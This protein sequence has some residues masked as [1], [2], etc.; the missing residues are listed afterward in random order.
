MQ[1]T[2]EPIHPTAH[3]APWSLPP[4]AQPTQSPSSC[5]PSPAG[6]CL[7]GGSARR[8]PGRES[9]AWSQPSL[10]RRPGHGATEG[11]A[12][13]VPANTERL[14]HRRGCL[15]PGG[16]KQ[17]PGPDLFPSSPPC[18][19][20]CLQFPVTDVPGPGRSAVSA[21]RPTC[22]FRACCVPLRSVRAT[23]SLP[24]LRLT[25]EPSWAPPGPQQMLSA[26]PVA[27]T[28]DPT[29][30]PSSSVFL[31][32]LAS[33]LAPSVCSLSIQRVLQ[34]PGQTLH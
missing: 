16:R 14:A 28:R 34:H 8:Q 18:S 31:L 1:K 25:W 9:G 30:P 13:E 21:L 15:W 19:T 7:L 3:S 23:P 17:Q 29:P 6:L 24:V 10:G 2:S 27:S 26:L 5:T 11:E 4:Q 20:V 33:A 32:L 22:A 12:L